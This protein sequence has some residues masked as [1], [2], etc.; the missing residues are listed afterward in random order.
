MILKKVPLSQQIFFSMIGL[1]SLALLVVA[2]INIRQIKKETTSYN[3]ERLARKDRAVAKS[4]EAIINLS[5]KYNVD[6]K[7]AFKPILKD[8][9]YIHK[10]K[11][12]IYNLDGSFVWSSDSTLIKNSIIT[13]PIPQNLIDSCFSS[14]VK[15]IKYEK[16][17]YFGTY[18]VLYKSESSAGLTSSEPII[19]DQPFCILDVIYDKSMKE[20]VLSKTNQQIKRLIKLYI[21]L[22]MFA[23]FLAY[24]VLQQITSPL[25]SIS[26]HLS[27][28][29]G[30]NMYKPLRWP[31]NDEIGQLINEYNKLMMELDVRTQQLIKSEKEGAWKEMARQIAHEIKNPLTPMRLNVQ[32]LLKS[33]KDGVGIGLYSDNWK[34][35]LENFSKTMIQQIDTLTHIANSFSDF[36]NINSRFEEEFIIQEEIERIVQLFKNNNVKFRTTLK[37]RHDTKVYMDKTHL[38]RIINNLV[39]NSLQA[40][41]PNTP[42]EVIVELGI[43]PNNC[44][45]LVSDNGLGI[46]HEIKDKIFEPN[47]TTK[48]SG[49]GLGLSMIKKII[50]DFNG[51]INYITSDRGTVFKVTIPITK[52]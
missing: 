2:T 18:R 52:K 4:I 46:A 34:E 13:R 38:T 50:T 27:L 40:E 1:M 28:A 41:K 43:E 16:G 47:F 20:E 39:K 26:L 25:R 7:K 44:I 5:P 45:V 3:V 33:F 24:F 17:G 10:L 14:N 30:E 29:K 42:I 19:T 21:A 23:G 48:N 9:G 32:Y 22:F 31:V 15:K 8:V 6:L 12:N 37:D 51:K 35:K 11:I 49:M 36:A